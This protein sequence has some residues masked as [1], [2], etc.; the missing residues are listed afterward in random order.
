MIR[1]EIIN[2]KNNDSVHRCSLMYLK[3]LEEEHLYLGKA[4]TKDK[5]FNSVRQSHILPGEFSCIHKTVRI[6][7]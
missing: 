4:M 6:I 3:K 2:G 1:I 5:M 7:R